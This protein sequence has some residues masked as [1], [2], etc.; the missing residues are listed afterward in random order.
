[1][2]HIEIDNIEI[3]SVINSSTSNLCKIYS[4]PYNN[5]SGMCT[6]NYNWL[7]MVEILGPNHIFTATQI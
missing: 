5:T 1:M 2:E 7:Q 6:A 3:N 4:M